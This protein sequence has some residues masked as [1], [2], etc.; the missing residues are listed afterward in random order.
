MLLDST[1]GPWLPDMP[2]Y[3]NPG[4]TVAYNVSP[5]PGT[6]QGAIAYE[7]V[8]AA[9][10][11][12]ASASMTSRPLGTAVGKDRLGV[13]KVYAGNTTQLCKINPSTSN[14]Q[15]IS[16]SGGY[17]TAEGE[18]W[19]TT[20]Y[21]GNV[22]FTNYSNEI[23]WIDKN[24]DTQFANATTLVKARHIAT[25]KNFVVVGNTFDA[26]DGA[27]PFRVRWSGL[28]LPL[29]WDF[30]QATGADFQ[31]I[32]GYGAIQAIVGGEL[33]WILMEQ[34]VVKMTFDG[35][36]LWFRFDPVAKSK[37]C[38]VAES[39]I[40]NV[41]GYTYFLASDGFYRMDE[42][43]GQTTAIG[44]GI[45]DT[46]LASVDTGQYDWM[47]VA[48]DP[49]KKLIYWS[50]ISTDAEDGTPDRMLIYNYQTGSFSQSD[51]TADFVFNALSLPWTIEALD[52]FGS[53]EDVPASFDSP[54]WAGGNA[55]LWAMKKNGSI[56]VFS[57]DTLP[58]TI[59][60]GELSYADILR[61]AQQ[62]NSD[63][64]TV[65]AV[66][67]LFDGGGIASVAIG[68]RTL[69]NDD[70]TY[71]PRKQLHPHTGFAYFRSTDRYH[72][73]RLRLTGDWAKAMS[74]QIDAQNAG[75]R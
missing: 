5:A 53:V 14:W 62:G 69:S 47:T 52:V 21:N 26:A 17:A 74:L 3:Q 57:G 54:I 40:R 63:K 19:E 56:W 67:A 73:F 49:R 39:V 48:A 9:K 42:V 43:T 64:A 4:V 44:S 33:G 8:Y 31:D 25:V 71:V 23:Q 10:A 24:I 1:F 36:P 70:I 32:P 51:A 55:M 59:E 38:A 66:R 11:Y 61:Q 68:T 60:T 50:Y 12:Y 6:Q 34:G 27:M 58:A 16:R 29:S 28:D 2:D 30:S 15:N 46:F 20:E 37:G 45:D 72:R 75:W 35:F 22:F 65:K 41:D 18:R 7:P 13:A